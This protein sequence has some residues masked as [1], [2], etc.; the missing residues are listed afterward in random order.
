MPAESVERVVRVLPDV[1]AL[2]KTFDYTVPD[3]FAGLVRVGTQV[4][5]VLGG[6]RVG[7]WVVED[8]VVAPPGVALRPISAVRG[9]GPPPAV[10]DLARWAAWRWA[11]PVPVFLRTASPPVAVRGLPDADSPARRGSGSGALSSS[12]ELGPGVSVVRLGPASDPWPLVLAAAAR[13]ERAG[14]DAGALVLAP[15]HR[16]ARDV[17]RRLRAGGIATALLPG[18]WARARAGGCVV[19]GARAGAFAPVP[20]LAAAVVLD[21][22]DEAYHEERAPTW[23]AWAVVVERARR[24]GAPCALVSPCPTLE[25][26]A[27]GPR[28]DPPR[29]V[30]RRGWPVVEV[31]DRRGDDPRTGIFSE[32]LVRLVRETAESPGRRLVCVVN[33]TGRVRLLSCAACGELARCEVCSGALELVGA[34]GKG[35]RGRGSPPDTGSPG[36]PPRL[37]CRRC[38]EERPV[39]CARCGAGRMKAL[40]LGVTRVREDLEALAG[41][42]V[43]EVWGPAASD[44]GEEQDVGRARV[45]VGTEAALHRVLDADAVAF[46]EFDSELLAPRFR[47]AEEALAL[48]ARAARLVAGPGPGRTDPGRIAD[49]APGRVVVQTRQPRHPAILAAVAAD[50]GIL[51]VE[52]STVRQALALPPFSALAVV[53]GSEAGAYGAALRGAAP[54]GVDVS[55]PVDGSWSVR[56]RDHDTLCDLLSSVARPSGRLRV[57][58]DPVRA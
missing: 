46:L 25:I 37:R 26:L 24:E 22:H 28:L 54:R 45:V 10:L 31:I 30:E 23:A 50:P 3:S 42:A 20:R 49:R 32:R 21:A 17:A 5:V 44:E 1:S 51:A 16:A 56:A 53:S 13:R 52:E 34:T 29:T 55:G 38:G 7:G 58:V 19:V 27:V 15:S 8:H 48:L 6:R 2:R 57:E 41:V 47:A 14:H 4:R 33:R 35:G 39:V 40:R 18:D 43:A 9:W 36:P 12:T 11:G